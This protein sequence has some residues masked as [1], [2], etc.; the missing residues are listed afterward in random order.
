[1]LPRETPCLI[2]C[3]IA[4]TQFR[5]LSLISNRQRYDSIYVLPYVTSYV[6]V[7]IWREAN[8]H[9]HHHHHHL[10]WALL[11]FCLASVHDQIIARFIP[12]QRGGICGKKE[13]W[14]SNIQ[15]MQRALFSC[16]LVISSSQN[17]VQADLVAMLGCF[18]NTVTEASNAPH[19]GW[20]KRKKFLD[21]C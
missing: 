9:H 4:A 19:I 5:G 18:L 16:F 1:M 12:F 20:I 3:L 6:C 13:S 2:N 17:W 7:Y 11:W 14:V 21:H 10:R 15:P 8:A